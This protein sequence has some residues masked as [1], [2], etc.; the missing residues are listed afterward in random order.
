MQANVV[1][2]PVRPP[3]E[4]TPELV[5][6]ERPT[7]YVLEMVA[8]LEKLA[9]ADGQLALASMLGEVLRRHR[10]ADPAPVKKKG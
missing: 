6:V 1:P 9:A 3:V 8:E 10:H 2:F 4:T 5:E 7:S